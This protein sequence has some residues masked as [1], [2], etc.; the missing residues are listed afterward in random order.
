LPWTKT[1]YVPEAVVLNETV[2]V[3]DVPP[4]IQEGTL[5]DG[6]PN[7]LVDAPVNVIRSALNPNQPFSPVAVMTTLGDV[8][9][10]NAVTD[11]LAAVIATQGAVLTELLKVPARPVSA[12]GV[13]VPLEIVTQT[14]TAKF[15]GLH[16]E[17][18]WNPPEIPPTALVPVIL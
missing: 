18:V 12:S 7:P 14:F 9:P 15:E 3:H 16:V 4:V 8:A 5:N 6:A 2:V 17:S 13:P 11:E 10:F 1:R